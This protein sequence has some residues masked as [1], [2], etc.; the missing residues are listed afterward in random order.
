MGNAS[1]LMMFAPRFKQFGCDIG[2]EYLRRKGG[3]KVHGLCVGPTDLFQHVQQQLGPQA[4]LF[5][6]LEMEERLWLT[7]DPEPGLVETI[8]QELGVGAF[9]RIIIADRRIG[10]GFVRGGLC[11]PDNIGSLSVK[12]PTIIP[13]RYVA[14][15]YFFLDQVLAQTKPNCV[16]LYAVAGAPALCLAKMCKVRKIFF[17]RFQTIRIGDYYTIDEDIKG[18]LHNIARTYHTASNG[19]LELAQYKVQARQFLEEYRANPLQPGYTIQTKKY[20]PWKKT[21]RA[22][23]QTISTPFSSNISFHEKKNKIQKL[24]YVALTIWRQAFTSDK[25]FS[26]CIP[27]KDKFVF[28]PLHVEPEA[29]TMV[30]SPYHTDQISVIEALAKSAPANM[31]VV[32]KEHG[33]MLGK[34]PPNFYKTISRIPRVVLLGPDHSS[35]SII[36]KASLV[37]VITGTAAWE[38]MLLKKP[39]LVIGDSPFL[40]IGQGVLHEP[41]LA[42]LPHAIPTALALPPV[43]DEALEIYLAACFA[44]SFSMSNSLLW[45]RYEGHS[46]GEMTKAINN[47]VDCII[48]REIYFENS[49]I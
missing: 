6:H 39:A 40:A 12:D 34:R 13:E 3:G 41:C 47:V 27:R 15:L 14:G 17:A 48:N 22:L 30:I 9:A 32:V 42:N 25:F 4:G 44:E 46:K 33:P 18:R 23:F 10:R 26:S 31:L 45:K 16:F 38:A 2:M 24:W 43:T 37:A 21:A 28:F 35:L 5:W 49:K 7:K 8:D 1:I 20:F 11:K 19:Q 29:S 36:R